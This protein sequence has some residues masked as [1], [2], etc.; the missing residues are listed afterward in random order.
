M[1]IDRIDEVSRQDGGS[2]WQVQF[3]GMGL[4]VFDTSR[5]A[6]AANWTTGIS[7]TEF[8][9]AA[10]GVTDLSKADATVDLSDGKLETLQGSDLLEFARYHKDLVDEACKFLRLDLSDTQSFLYHVLPKDN[11]TLVG[12]IDVPVEYWY[13][14]HYK[15]EKFIDMTVRPHEIAPDVMGLLGD[16][17][18]RA[19]T[20]THDHG[21]EL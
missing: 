3:D 19:E 15:I 18:L 5:E 12:F 14:D 13:M 6:F 1:G 7:P 8:I 20:L 4:A 10:S 2:A 17:W 16:L 11:L 9:D 21:G